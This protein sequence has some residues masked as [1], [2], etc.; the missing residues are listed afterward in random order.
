MGYK[1]LFIF[2]N[3]LGH[4]NPNLRVAKE[5]VDQ[6]HDVTYY[7]F[8]PFYKHVKDNTGANVKVL[9]FCI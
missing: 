4:I 1:I 6:G 7:T 2:S 8:P 9:T 5:L 3:Y